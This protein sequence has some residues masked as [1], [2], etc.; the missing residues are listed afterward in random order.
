MQSISAVSRQEAV[1]RLQQNVTLRAALKL[2]CFPRQMHNKH[3]S[4][5]HPTAA[6]F[7]T[8]PVSKV[9]AAA[10]T[11]PHWGWNPPAGSLA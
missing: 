4:T 6:T 9:H 11:V 10:F 1:M 8:S 7:D 5:A 3:P 2:G